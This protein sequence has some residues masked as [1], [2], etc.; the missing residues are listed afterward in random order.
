MA[1]Y[2]GWSDEDENALIY[3]LLDGAD[4]FEIQRY[5]PTP[6]HTPPRTM[7]AIKARVGHLYENGMVDIEIGT[8][9]PRNYWIQT[10]LDP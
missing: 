9:I 10:I 2:R 3:H 6:P 4:L 1:T 8:G 7:L 5:L